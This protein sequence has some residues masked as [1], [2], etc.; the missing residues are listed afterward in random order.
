M[1]ILIT[2]DDG[3]TSPGIR[4]LVERLSEDH[5]IIVVAPVEDMSGMGHSVTL[6]RSVAVRQYEMKNGIIAFGVEGTP[7]DCVGIGLKELADYPVDLVISGV[8]RG[9]NI[10]SDFHYS[11]TI[12]AAMEGSLLGLPAIAVS[13]ASS[14]FPHYESAV[15]VVETLMDI[16]DPR[17]LPALSILSIN[18]P[19]IP[20]REI[21]GWK[22]ARLSKKTRGLTFSKNLD[23]AGNMLF[24]RRVL[25]M[26]EDAFM[27]DDYNILKNNCVS[28][29]PV[30][31]IL[32]P[33]DEYCHELSQSLMETCDYISSPTRTRQASGQ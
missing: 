21:A 30:H 6:G 33:L 17:R 24:T 5:E 1:R 20:T 3:I 13:S 9:E 18:V 25:P 15:D 8:N 16:I 12:S 11:G 10:G 19:P 22:I 4:S 32:Y 26:N 2:N 28:I 27:K 23:E 14:L 7:A 31:A 29:T